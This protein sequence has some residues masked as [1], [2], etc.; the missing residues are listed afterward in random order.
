MNDVF[1]QTDRAL[2][3]AADLVG[4]ARGEVA[5]RCS[6]LSSRIADL[7][8]GWGGQGAAS[9]HTLMGTWQEKQ[10]LILKAL[11]QLAEALVETERDNVATDQ[12]Q[13]AAHSTLASRLG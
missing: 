9:F 7:M 13:A 8:G 2:S 3:R 11:D 1:G 12:S 4:S 10:E 6:E 5:G